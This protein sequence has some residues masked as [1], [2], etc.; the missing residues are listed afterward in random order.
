MQIKTTMRYCLTPVRTAL[1][2][3]WTDNKCWW[4]CGEKGNPSTLLVGMQT[5]TATVEN[6]MGSP[7]KIKN[8]TV[9]WL[10]KS[11]SG[12]ISK[13]PKTLIWKT[14]CTLVFIAVLF[15]IV[16]IWKHP[17]YPL[18]G[19]WIKKW[20]YIYIGEYYSTVKK[21]RRKSYPLRQHG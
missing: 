12:N 6:S 20:W 16:K 19:E 15:T 2:N 8:G 5:G 21:K 11:T 3:K 9:L 7:Q 4:G 17:K 13:E 1:I 14:I 10:W 18:V